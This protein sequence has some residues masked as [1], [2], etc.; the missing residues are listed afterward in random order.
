MVAIPSLGYLREQSHTKKKSLL[1]SKL[2]SQFYNILTCR[3]TRIGY[4][5]HF[6]EQ[7]LG[8][9]LTRDTGV[10]SSQFDLAIYP[11]SWK[12]QHQHWVLPLATTCSASTRCSRCQVF[13]PVWS[14]G[15]LHRHCGR[16]WEDDI[17]VIHNY[18]SKSSHMHASGYY[19][20]HNATPVTTL[21]FDLP[22]CVNKLVCDLM[23]LLA[24]YFVAYDHRY[25]GSWCLVFWDMWTHYSEHIRAQ[26]AS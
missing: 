8:H 11:G 21:S 4:G 26:Q 16:G 17:L 5:L 7:G 1:T 18:R 3:K 15:S 20:L 2:N 25:Y 22:P 9:T 13:H 14:K 6:Q 10:F 19:P 12:P 23:V 24:G